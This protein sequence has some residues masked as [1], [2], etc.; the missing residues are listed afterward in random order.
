MFPDIAK[1]L[2]GGKV[3]PDR[4]HW[5]ELYSGPQDENGGAS[6]PGGDQERGRAGLV[7]PEG[8]R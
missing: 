4:N 2:L 3:T 1:C 5:V 6:I 7:L 8:N